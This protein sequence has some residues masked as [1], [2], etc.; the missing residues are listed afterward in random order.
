MSRVISI[1]TKS[2]SFWKVNVFHTPVVMCST[3]VTED[4]DMWNIL[5]GCM[6]K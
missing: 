2:K 3:F 6:V 5:F 4:C 1:I